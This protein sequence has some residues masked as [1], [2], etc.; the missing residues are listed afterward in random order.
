[1]SFFVTKTTDEWGGTIY[2]PTAA[3][4]AAL[5]I[6][7]IAVLLIGVYLFGRKKHLSAK[8]LVFS[9]VAIA[10]SM[11]TSF[12]KLINMP[13]G[14]AVTLLSMLFVSLIGYWYGLGA[15]LTTAF[16]YGMLQLIIDPYIISVPQMLVDYVFAFMALGLSGLFSHAKNGLSKG[17][18]AS[19]LGRYF[20]SFLSG[21]IFFGTYAAAAGF[22]S[23][24]LYSLAY[25]GAYL[26]LE[27]LI[28]L[29]IINIPPVR[30]ALARVTLYARDLGRVK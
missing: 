24:V 15:G 30:Q 22:K 9:S 29:I 14:G 3:G 21:W 7:M 16:S 17:Y 25:N 23:A 1:M 2:Q 18:I 13:M 6:I 12:I 8:H 20:F 5:V 4:F 27:A 19:V 26:G 11:V 10:L 28:T